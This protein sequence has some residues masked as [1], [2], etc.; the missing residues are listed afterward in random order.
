MPEFPNPYRA[1]GARDVPEEPYGEEA[2]GDEPLVVDEVVD[3]FGAEDAAALLAQ[4]LKHVAAR[5]PEF[6]PD[7][8]ALL[9]P[10]CGGRD[11]FDGPIS[12]RTTLMAFGA[13]GTPWSRAL[14]K[15]LAHARQRHRVAWRHHPDPI[16][17]PRAPIL[18]LA[19]EAAATHGR[20][21]ALTRVL[22]KMRH[23]DPADLHDAMLRAGLDPD[24]TIAAMRSGLGTDRI[25]SDVASA[26]ASGVPVPPALFVNGE[27]YEGEL[28][29]AA[30]S[31]A[32]DAAARNP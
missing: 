9:W 21:W 25:V 13:F 16:A 7:G 11:R 27:R 24:L 31:A 6:S 3:V 19:V 10:P 12:S 4:R 32:L 26:L 29:P 15:V 30:V 17:H 1:L 8:R 23:D 2:L 14:G 28:D 22:L 5:P 18:A 20:F